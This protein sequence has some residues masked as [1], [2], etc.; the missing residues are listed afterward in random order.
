MVV[1]LFVGHEDVALYYITRVLCLFLVILFFLF[2]GCQ[3]SW[4]TN[5][6]VASGPQS[7]IDKYQEIEKEP[8]GH[9]FGFYL[10]SS[11]SKHL[12]RVDLYG[13][14]KS[15]F[16]IV[17]HEL[18]SPDNLCKIVL[19]DVNVRACTDQKVDQKWALTLYHVNRSDKPLKDAYPMK[20]GYDINAQDPGFISLLLSADRGP[21]ST[22][23]HRF[24]FEAVSLDEGTTLIHLRYSFRYSSWAYF[25]MKSYFSIFGRGMIGFSTVG[26]NSEGN[27]VY[28]RGLRGAVERNV[29]R[30][31]LAILAYIDTIKIRPEQRFE[32]RVS[33]WYDLTTRYPRQLFVM[34]KEEYLIYKR[35]DRANQ[36]RLQRV[37]VGN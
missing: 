9:S 18:R 35:R 32:R 8:H 20:F 10:E 27:A 12:S 30:Y 33:E 31:Y 23:D 7:L 19:L 24:G 13:T 28:V 3:V 25:L 34:E 6:V 26:T 36:L 17:S 22:Q 2:H 29:V 14:T 11:V 4:A 16:N 5:P 21:F 15:P 1:W 37:L